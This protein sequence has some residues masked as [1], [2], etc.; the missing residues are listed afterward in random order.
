MQ[1]RP[2][3]TKLLCAGVAVLSMT[4][5]A[6]AMEDESAAVAEAGLAP[7]VKRL[8]E[9]K[10][11]VGLAAMVMV[12]GKVVDQAADGERKQG[13]GVL[14]TTSDRWHLGSI[15][16]SITS[17]LIGRLVEAGKLDWDTTIG[18]ALAGQ[19]IHDDWRGV[20][21]TQLLTHTAGAPANFPMLVKLKNPAEG[22]PRV[23]A[24][25]EA[26]LG[27]IAKPPL[28]PPG[29]AFAY[30]N[31]GYT[32]AGV[33]AEQATGKPWEDLVRQEV[34]APLKLDQAGFGPPKSPAKGYDQPRG[35]VTRLGF[36]VAMGDDADNTPIMG[37]AGT[38]CMTLDELCCYANEH[39]R[40]EQGGGKLLS[41]ETYRRLHE[42]A[43]DD[44]AC[45]WVA[46]AEAD[47]VP[48][49]RWHNG[50]N[51]MWYAFV[52]FIPTNNMVVAITAND[53]DI[54]AA[55][56]AALQVLKASQSL[57]PASKTSQP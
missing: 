24:R 47:G 16:K 35:H 30:S 18:D 5:A 23:D 22:Q 12:D 33:M 54:R 36:K 48:A 14:V 40:G 1:L 37:P 46:R 50:S 3:L 34:F 17:T 15:T 41:A 27:V 26:V 8:R 9:E 21:L 4:A 44:Y 49:C 53:G 13:S 56:D 7:L 43:L 29:E 52:A 38:A 32:I 28:T 20:T 51:T 11:L 57:A 39:L 31:V 42:P 2:A 10:K 6:G 19:P 45:G 55:E 25:R